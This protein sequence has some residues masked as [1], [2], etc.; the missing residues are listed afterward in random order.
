MLDPK[1]KHPM[2]MPDGTVV[3]QVVHL[4]EVIDHPRIEVGEFSYHHNQETVDDYAAHLAPYLFTISLDRLVIGKFVQIA[5]GV[6]FITSSANHAMQ[7][8]ST[9][10]FDN[11]LMTSETTADDIVSMFEKAGNRGDTVVG[12]DVWIGMDATVM[13]GVVI[14]DGAIIG[15][16]SVVTAD[17]EP[18][19]IVAGNPARPIRK[20]FDKATIEALQTIRWWDWPIEKIE[21]SMEVIT[22]ADLDALKALV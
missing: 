22:G 1:R 10:P 3:T 5:H 4:K 14:G 15:S 11:F 7:G 20:R 13:P 12:N 2:V 19:A 16:K 17:V 8:F 6:R 18:Y 21:A 9:Y